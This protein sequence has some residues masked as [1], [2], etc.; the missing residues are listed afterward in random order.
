MEGHLSYKATAQGRVLSW[1]GFA[2]QLCE[3][4]GWEKGREEGGK[5]GRRE[6]RK[7]GREEGGKGGRREGRKR[8]VVLSSPF[9]S[10]PSPSAVVSSLAPDSRPPH[11]LP[12]GPRGCRRDGPYS[13]PSVVEPK[14]SAWTYRHSC[15]FLA[16]TCWKFLLHVLPPY[17][18]W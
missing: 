4:S 9:S 3:W 2:P 17:P 11:D 5:G 15:A 7:E 1:V 12:L 16:Q 10:P 13:C 18:D 6:G 8:V 14:Q